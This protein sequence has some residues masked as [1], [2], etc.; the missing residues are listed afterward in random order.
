MESTEELIVYHSSMRIPYRWAAGTVAARFYRELAQHQL[1]GTRCPQSQKVLFPPRKNC[2][3]CL[4]ETT[5]WVK[6]GP[7]G[8]VKSFTVAHYNVALLNEPTIYALI[9]LDGADTAFIH[10]LKKVNPQ[11]LDIGMRVTAVFAPEPQGTI[12]DIDY[13]Q[14]VT[15][16]AV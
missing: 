4:Q 9:Q 6:V 7:Q 16:E 2:N 14:P 8:S 3:C 11:Q 13:F 10:R 15:I 5:D 1:F 12:L